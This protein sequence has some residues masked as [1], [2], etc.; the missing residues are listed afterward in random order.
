MICQPELIFEQIRNK[1]TELQAQG[2]NIDSDINRTQRRLAEIDQ[3]RLAYSRQQARGKI[4]ESEYD[5]LVGECD[6]M[7]ADQQEKL[8]H[9]MA[10][11]DEKERVDSSIGFAGTPTTVVS[12]GTSFMTTAPRPTVTL[13]PIMALFRMQHLGASQA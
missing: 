4:S 2:D 7:A 11:R 6:E 5:L 12:S 13:F 1:R 8:S 3:E 9:L 10:L